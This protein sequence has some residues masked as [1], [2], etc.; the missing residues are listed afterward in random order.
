MKDIIVVLPG[1]MGSVLRKNNEDVWAPSGGAVWNFLKSRSKSIRGL[2]LA[3][4]D[5]GTLDTLGDGVEATGLMP[6]VHLIPGLFAIDGYSGIRKYIL[7]TFDVVENDNYIEFPYDWRRNNEAHGRR[8]RQE[9]TVWLDR[10]R[11]K[12]GNPDAKLVLVAHSMGGLVARSFL[13]LND[14]WQDTRRLVTFGTPFQGSLSSLDFIVNGFKKGKGPI[15]IDLSELVRSLT[16]IQQLLPSVECINEGGQN[17]GIDDIAVPHLRADLA[18]AALD[19]HRKINAAAAAG[20]GPIDPIVGIRQPTL[21]AATIDGTKLTL[22]K[23]LVTAG[24]EMAGDGTVPRWSATPL[25]MSTDFTGTV[26]TAGQHG[27][28]QNTTTALTHLE[29][30]LTEAPAPPFQQA[31]PTDFIGIDLDDFYEEGEDVSLEL[32]SG[33]LNPTFHIEITDH[34]TGQDAVPPIDVDNLDGD[35]T[36]TE[37][38]GGLTAGTYRVTVTTPGIDASPV[39]RPFLVGTDQ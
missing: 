23:K 31:G 25:E 11:T 28:L 24:V 36:M 22:T 6:D 10:W 37:T 17:K 29:G 39:S 3:G 35:E 5:D 34:T 21:Q 30:L 16:S 26:Y 38:I 2:A 4:H 9:A 13:E 27:E 18:T 32:T 33:A 19:F 7:E 12:S 1:I 14:G 20:N 15:G 8:L